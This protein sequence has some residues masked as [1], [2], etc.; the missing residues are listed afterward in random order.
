MA[1]KRIS[2]QPV[3][4]GGTGNSSLT[5]H[6]VL[7]G[8]SGN[9]INSTVPGTTGQVL[10]GSTGT[11]PAFQALGF[12]SS[13]TANG[14]LLGNNLSAITATAPGTTGQVLTGVTGSAPTFQTPTAPTSSVLN[15]TY[16]D[17]G[18]SPYTV[19]LTDQFLGVDSSGGA[20]TLLLPDTPPTG[21]YWTVKDITGDSRFN[22]ITINTVSGSDNIDSLTTYTLMSSWSSI[23]ALFNGAA[24]NIF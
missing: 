18:A 10:V 20:V 17:N 5:I 22:F 9:P 11:D 15:Y 3:I 1:Y 23:N 7:I 14:V 6:G 12:N 13:L 16:I 24:Y 4:E 2:P 19:L 8:E 21:Q